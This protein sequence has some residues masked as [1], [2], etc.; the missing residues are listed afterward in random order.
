MSRFSTRKPRVP[1]FRFDATMCHF[2]PLFNVMSSGSSC[3]CGS[4]TYVPSPGVCHLLKCWSS[5]LPSGCVALVTASQSTAGVSPKLPAATGDASEAVS[6]SKRGVDSSIIS[7]ILRLTSSSQ[8]KYVISAEQK[9]ESTIHVWMC[10][11][12]CVLQ[13]SILV[14]MS[15]VFINCLRVEQP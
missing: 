10:V 3:S 14:G 13:A 7:L 9:T 12:V 15:E 5:T 6:P 11:D 1:W 2:F 4:C 8:P